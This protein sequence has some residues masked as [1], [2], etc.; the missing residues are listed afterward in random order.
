MQDLRCY[1][2]RPPTKVAS[3]A[4][5]RS[6]GSRILAQLPRDPLETSRRNLGSARELPTQPRDVYMEVLDASEPTGSG[7]AEPKV[8]EKTDDEEARGLRHTVAAKDLSVRT[9][10]VLGIF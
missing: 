9:L 3:Y 2:E 10:K 8:E 1:G 6:S 7:T 4:R 5:P